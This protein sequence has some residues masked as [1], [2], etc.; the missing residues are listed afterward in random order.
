MAAA[1]ILRRHVGLSSHDDNTFALHLTVRCRLSPF[2][3][4]QPSCSHTVVFW[5]LQRQV[6]RNKQGPR[7]TAFKAIPRIARSVDRHSGGLSDPRL[8]RHLP[9]IRCSP[10][11][12]ASCPPC[13]PPH[14][15]PP[16]T[17][18]H[19]PPANRRRR[20]PKQRR[21]S[22]SGSA[23]NGSARCR[24]ARGSRGRCRCLRRCL[25]RATIHTAHKTIIMETRRRARQSSPKRPLLC[26][27]WPRS[28]R[29][30]S[31]RGSARTR[32]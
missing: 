16:E 2:I 5:T 29:L 23:R 18:A 6:G 21:T 28:A 8:D 4:L 25:Y 31:L 11:R 20:P 3:H 15:G 7:G 32:A 30:G 26:E 22:S 12:L 1:C 27:R 17:L 9:R 13:P 24:I 10:C 14:L 19:L